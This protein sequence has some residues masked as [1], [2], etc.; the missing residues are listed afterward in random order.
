MTSQSGCQAQ[1][2]IQ[3]LLPP[4]LM[5]TKLQNWGFTIVSVEAMNQFH[6]INLLKLVEADHEILITLPVVI[7]GQ[8]TGL[9]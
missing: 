3:T 2:P 6:F 1:L 9:E 4:F 7:L 8:R 5:A